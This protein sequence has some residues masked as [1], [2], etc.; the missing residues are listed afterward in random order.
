MDDFDKTYQL[1]RSAKKVETEK[2][3]K[4]HFKTSEISQKLADCLQ[5][6]CCF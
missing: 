2:K 1:K 5:L 6:Y 3:C 4:K